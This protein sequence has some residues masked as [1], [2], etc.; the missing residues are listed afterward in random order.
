MAGSNRVARRVRG[1]VLQTKY[2]VLAGYYKLAKAARVIMRRVSL[3]ARILGF[4][5]GGR[6]SI[7]L[8]AANFNHKYRMKICPICSKIVNK[9]CTY[10]SR[11]CSNISRGPRSENT[12]IKLRLFA[13]TNPTGWAKNPLLSKNQKGI[14]RAK[15]DSRLCPT[16]NNFF[17]IRSSNTKRFCSSMCIRR[18]GERK[19]TGR[20]K[21][22]WYKGIY[23]GSTYELAFLIWNLDHNI[24]ISRC[25]ESFEYEYLG[26]SRK[27]H[28]DFVVNNQIIEIK[29]RQQP[30]DLIK[31]NAANAIMI[32]KETIIPYINYVVQKYKVHKTK[33]YTLYEN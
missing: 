19:H 27:Y 17:I 33:L 32:D 20:A 21:T 9:G 14:I 5:P 26:K 30:V 4:H 16:C 25:T 15:Q 12:K 13:N 7:L 22:G 28:P 11:S 31:I 23:C 6:R 2:A 3:L 18:G 29:G 10:C 8:R 24:S 1:P